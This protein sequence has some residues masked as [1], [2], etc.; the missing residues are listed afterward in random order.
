MLLMSLMP[1][2]DRVLNRIRLTDGQPHLH[3]PAE[4]AHLTGKDEDWEREPGFLQQLWK[5]M[6][7]VPGPHWQH[8]A[9]L[10]DGLA[11]GGQDGGAGKPLQE[12][13]LRVRSEPL[14]VRCHQSA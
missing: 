12:W 14:E 3:L 10:V 6:R 9:V 4:V 2:T 11:E 7:M 8:Q 1:S 13:G 5:D